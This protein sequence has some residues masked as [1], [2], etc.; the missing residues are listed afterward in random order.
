M[1]GVKGK[2][3][4]RRA[5]S[6]R[7]PAPPVFMSE[8]TPPPV[9]EVGCGQEPDSIRLLRAVVTNPEIP[10]K[11]RLEAAKALAPYEAPKK[12]DVGKKEDR[13]QKAKAASG[14]KFAPAAPPKLVSNLGKIVK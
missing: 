13:A 3:G 4:G 2:S 9:L 8:P 10:V 5:G 11:L 6:G 7:K 14:G 1:A 12:G